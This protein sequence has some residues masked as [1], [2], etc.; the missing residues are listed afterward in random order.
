MRALS[1]ISRGRAFTLIE[2]LVVVAIIALLI[3]ILLPSLQRAKEQARMAK[4]AANLRSIGQAVE[5]CRTEHNGYGPM[6]DDGECSAPDGHVIMMVTWVDV[7]WEEGFVDDWHIGICPT[8][9]RPDIP[10]EI[11]AHRDHWNYKF[12]ED[13]GLRLPR[14]H[15]VRTS[16]ALSGVAHLN[17]PKNNYPDTARQVY[18]IDGWWTWFGSLNA[19]WVASGGEYGQYDPVG[20]PRYDA[21][22]VGWRHMEYAANTLFYDGHVRPIVPNLAG[23]VYPSTLDNPDRTVDTTRSFMFLPGERTDRETWGVYYGEVDAWH[24]KSPETGGKE[25]EEANGM[26]VPA[27][28]PEEDLCPNVKTVR[29]LWKKLPADPRYRR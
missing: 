12:S 29:R 2:L 16:Y 21:T 1:N 28:Y 3:S 20:W 22:M 17:N 4:C 18:A 13:F 27:D 9:K 25:I 26:T 19:M 24:G 8:D 11:R 5:T 7:L 15:G 6:W 23:F 10:T 14:R